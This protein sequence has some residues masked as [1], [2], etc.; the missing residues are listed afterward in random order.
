MNE[1]LRKLEE[2]LKKLTGSTY[3]EV[4]R[5]VCKEALSFFQNTP[6][7]PIFEEK[8][9][10]VVALD[11][12]LSTA[13]Y[14]KIAAM[15]LPQ[16]MALV[17]NDFFAGKALSVILSSFLNA[18]LSLGI[19]QSIQ[20][21]IFS[22]N[23]IIKDFPN[24]SI[25]SP[26][27][28]LDFRLMTKSD[29]MISTTA[30][31][32]FQ[33]LFTYFVGEIQKLDQN[34]IHE[35][36]VSDVRKKFPHD[37]NQETNDRSCLC[38]ILVKI[39]SDLIG[40]L[41]NLKPQFLDTP[42][43]PVSVIYETLNI[44]TQ[45]AR[46]L[47]VEDISLSCVLQGSVMQLLNVL[48]A[49]KFIIT[50][51]ESTLPSGL[52]IFQMTVKEMIAMIRP[53][54][55]SISTSIYF[56]HSFLIHKKVSFTG[57]L[58]KCDE[59]TSIFNS[60]LTTIVSYTA[61]ATTCEP[62]QLE[63]SPI[64]LQ[65]NKAGLVP[66]TAQQLTKYV[67]EV[68]YL[69][70]SD[71]ADQE[72]C[73]NITKRCWES[74]LD[75]TM[76]TIRFIATRKVQT[77]LNICIKLLHS[78]KLYC[79]PKDLKKAVSYLAN[80]YSLT[81]NGQLSK[82]EAIV[83]CIRDKE[84]IWTSFICD[85][86]SSEMNVCAGCWDVLLHNIFIDEEEDSSQKHFHKKQN[87]SDTAERSMT[88]ET[89]SC[90]FTCMLRA[91]FAV[92]FP[93]NDKIDIL[94]ALLTCKFIPFLF[95]S[96]FVHE[97]IESFEALWPR[98]EVFFIQ[99]LANGSFI[100]DAL[101]LFQQILQKCFNGSTEELLCH[102]IA[103]IVKQETNI[104]TKSLIS[105]LS[106]VRSIIQKNAACITKGWV[107]LFTA[108]SPG[109]VKSNT[110][111][112]SVA[113]GIINMICN[114][115]LS[116]IN[117]NNAVVGI[118]N[119]IFD[120]AKQK[121]DIN[122]SLSSLDL[123]WVMSN[124]SFMQH[125]TEMWT[126]VFSE[127]TKLFFDERVV[128]ANSA[129]STLF[130]L[131]SS[132]SDKIPESVFESFLE[133]N[134]PNFIGELFSNDNFVV[135]Q[136][137]LQ[138][139][140][141]YI[142]GFWN[143]CEELSTFYTKVLPELISSMTKLALTCKNQELVANGFEFYLTFCSCSEFTPKAA[144]LIY[145]SITEISAEYAKRSVT[146]DPNSL[147]LTVFGRNVGRSLEAMRNLFV[148]KRIS[149]K[150]WSEFVYKAAL[151]YK[152]QK[153]VQI[154]VQK[155]L[156]GLGKVLPLPEGQF[157]PV[158]LSFV[159]IIEESDNLAVKQLCI[160]LLT[161]A[162]EATDDGQQKLQ[163][164][165]LCKP[166]INMKEAKSL[167]D[168]LK[169]AD[170][171]TEDK[172]TLF[173]CLSS[174]TSFEKESGE[175]NAANIN[176]LVT[177]IPYVDA[178]TQKKFVK[179]LDNSVDVLIKLFNMFMRKNSETYSADVVANIYSE[180]FAQ[181]SSLKLENEEEEMKYITFIK[182]NGLALEGLEQ[183]RKSFLLSMFACVNKLVTSKSEKVRLEVQFVLQKI[184]EITRVLI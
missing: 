61:F 126:I 11:F 122:I 132:N 174:L 8:S 182:E 3:P 31:A 164:F 154:T 104:D 6:N 152:S 120:F 50:F 92:K 81:N 170:I 2:E 153:L 156:E 175:E 86:I 183:D 17:E 4:L 19:D 89:T 7:P 76:T 172:K 179:E 159:H 105:I 97:E 28:S 134:F 41:Q 107:D 59:G 78:I 91:S 111:A 35:N 29:E 150:A 146:S 166:I 72:G 161:T 115:C 87:S 163:Y 64:K 108:I 102:G 12:I 46:D 178:D 125:S 68:L 138:E 43:L 73:Q 39:L 33:Q 34:S 181:F 66:L 36:F 169:K 121:V 9:T 168:A 112:L 51:F 77:L 99:A 79:E 20:L 90:E 135:I 18:S 69:L 100:R 110:E 140:A 143:K 98:L 127:C 85:I 131:L 129:V 147:S 42:L 63:L 171:D 47:I 148:E 14:T 13:N 160:S 83:F 52:D 67:I 96:D 32:S 15:I 95:V 137:L 10:I 57:I 93:I 180:W 165:I 157:E 24:F 71:F 62:P 117:D 60:L 54:S 56:F 84:K 158:V 184:E 25:I 88:R 177:L 30:I 58:E 26:L 82:N 49:T 130:N 162:F 167:K 142:C 40:M 55:K 136:Q 114:D 70:L 101:P 48:D 106:E 37:V 149:T 80:I 113:T 45:T 38:L 151:E 144:D 23:F 27:L 145:Q 128:L 44:F 16:T 141:H 22:S 103:K 133:V 53:K 94:D 123:L 116:L 124:T 173:I 176:K 21:L 139:I 65:R 118:I 1:N 109:N 75:A 155:I 74:L 119:C 5:S